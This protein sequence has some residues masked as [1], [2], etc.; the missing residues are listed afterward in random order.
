MHFALHYRCIIA[1]SS[2]TALRSALYY[3]SPTASRSAL[4]LVLS[5]TC[6]GARG[7]P[8]GAGVH[9]ETVR[10]GV[11]EA[12]IRAGVQRRQRAA[13]GPRRAVPVGEHRAGD[14]HED[15]E[16]E[17]RGGRSVHGGRRKGRH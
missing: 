6:Y 1:Q 7:A 9:L 14:G 17:Q 3:R 4:G 5:L 16:G 12:G 8:V 11:G 13:G 2:H 10:V 15:E